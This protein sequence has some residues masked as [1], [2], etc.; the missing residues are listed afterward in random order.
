MKVEL[1]M[2]KIEAGFLLKLRGDV[3]M[4][5]SSD[6]RNAMAQVFKQELSGMKALLIDLS[7]VRYMDSSGIATLIEGMQNCVKKGVRLRLCELSPAVRDV[8]ELARLGS[9]F[10]IYPTITDAKTGL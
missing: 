7:Q 3:D 10:E 4:N 2:E 1:T 8:F 9:V 6:V 5:T